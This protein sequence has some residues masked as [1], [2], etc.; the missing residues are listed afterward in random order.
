MCG[1]TGY[2]RIKENEDFLHSVLRETFLA[3]QS[4]GTDASGFSTFT[5]GEIRVVKSGVAASELVKK[6]VFQ[7]VIDPDLFI[8]HTRFATHG[9]HKNNKNNHPHYT[10]D[11]KYIL[12]HNGVILSRPRKLKTESECDSEILLRLIEKYGIK[13]GFHRIGQ[14]ENS[15]YAI[16]ILVPEERA[17]YIYR[18][19][20]PLWYINLTLEIGGLLFVSTLELLKEGIK[21]AGVEVYN[22]DKR[23]VEIQSGVLYKFTDG[24]CA[25]K[26]TVISCKARTQYVYS[27][28]GGNYGK[29]KTKQLRNRSTSV[30]QFGR[31]K[32]V[33]SYL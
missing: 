4:R 31:G 29:G 23:A 13:E 26:T 20:S 27:Y 24:D 8:A 14:L 10:K 21:N 6:E 15:S 1:V 17:I 12:I 16:M 25:P 33:S 28:Y 2:V 18:N 3:I 11:L 7:N 22:L 5:D 19:T 9:S 32:R 30:S